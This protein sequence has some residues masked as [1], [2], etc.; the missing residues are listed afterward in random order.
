MRTLIFCAERLVCRAIGWSSG[1]WYVTV[2]S[3]A[4]IECSRRNVSDIKGQSDP[5]IRLCLEYCLTI[6]CSGR[7]CPNTSMSV[8]HLVVVSK[9]SCLTRTISA[10]RRVADDENTQS[11]QERRSFMP[12]VSHPSQI[13]VRSYHTLLRQM[14]WFF[15]VVIRSIFGWD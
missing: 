12:T 8:D 5:L 10:A 1:N 6:R 14:P 3:R 4:E 9:V 13:C 11:T 15:V 2:D 7:T